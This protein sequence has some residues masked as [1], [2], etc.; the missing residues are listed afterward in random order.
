MADEYEITAVF[1]EA[2]DWIIEAFP[3]SFR[4]KENQRCKAFYRDEV[5][6]LFKAVFPDMKEPSKPP[7]R[8]WWFIALCLMPISRRFNMNRVTEHLHDLLS[9]DETE[10]SPLFSVGTTQR[11]SGSQQ[12]KRSWSFS[13]VT[14][15]VPYRHLEMEEKLLVSANF[16]KILEGEFQE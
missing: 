11:A 14:S 8:T 5:W 3:E 15:S 7:P 1:K 4:G 12:S 2:E 13:T 16:I 9:S 10:K 6:K